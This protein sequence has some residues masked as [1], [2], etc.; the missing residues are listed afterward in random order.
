MGYSN[1]TP[2]RSFTPGK[3]SNAATLLPKPKASAKADKPKASKPKASKPKVE[4]R[5]VNGKKFK[6]TVL[7]SEYKPTPLTIVS[8]A[9]KVRLSNGKVDPTMIPGTHR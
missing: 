5:T 4:Y 6:V 2:K 9:G 1:H 7:H 8:K 3:W